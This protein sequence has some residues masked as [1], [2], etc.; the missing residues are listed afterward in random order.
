MKERIA[1]F[2]GVVVVLVLLFGRA[3]F[4]G[5]LPADYT[6]MM[7]TYHLSVICSAYGERLLSGNS[8][9]WME[10]FGA[11]YPIHALW[12]YGSFSTTS[13]FWA[14]L[15]LESAYSWGAIL[16]LAFGAAGIHALMRARG[17]HRAGA[18]TAG[19]VFAVC[20]YTIGKAATG[21]VNQLW[22]LTWAPWVLWA[23]HGAVHDRRHGVSLLALVGALGLLAGHIQIWFFLAPLAVAYALVEVST[24]EARRA[25][26]SRLGLASLLIILITAVQSLPTIEFALIAERPET[27]QSFLEL[28]SAPMYALF[29]K[30]APGMLGFRPGSYLGDEAFDN[31]HSGLGGAAVLLLVL[32]AV[33]RDRRRVLLALAALLG[34]VLAVGVRVPAIGW[35][36]ELPLIGWGR[37]AARS[38]VLTV[39]AG[40]M[41]AGHGVSDLLTARATPW[42]RIA[43]AGG[44]TLAALLTGGIVVKSALSNLVWP[45]AIDGAQMTLTDAFWSVVMPALLLSLLGAV[46]VLAAVLL[47]RRRPMLAPVVAIAALLGVWMAGLPP[48]EPVRTTFFETSWRDRIPVDLADNRVL[49][50]D[51]RVPYVELDGFR[52]FRRPA[53][54]DTRYMGALLEQLG[55]AGAKW[56]DV[57][58][59][60]RRHMHG[61]GPPLGLAQR[62]D[63]FRQGIP[64]IGRGRFFRSA[65]S[66]VPDEEVLQILARGDE[67]LFLATP[68][69]GG[70]ASRGKDVEVRTRG[71]GT[72]LICE[73]EV[74]T[75]G[76]LFV[77]EKW[78]P[79][80][81]CSVNDQPVAISRANVAFRAVPIPVGRSTVKFNYRPRSVLVGALATL[82]GLIL[83][84]VLHYRGRA[85]AVPEAE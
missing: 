11:G 29:S 49:M 4:P 30:V 34:L 56:L 74:P 27:K 71:I 76:W 82:L 20:E 81:N 73:L 18:L 53:H 9:L 70:S 36:H 39:L 61:R 33:T 41:L 15:P 85:P 25:A 1:L 72:E 60:I 8:P 59:E 44:V 55:P 58:T 46:L 65:K 16:H 28:W 43:V 52:G 37:V 10:Q 78:Y 68:E 63:V 48:I 69:V 83:T 3:A 51:L 75:A 35:L 79:G 77:S 14:L 67:A 64:A 57:G 84:G 47:V 13:L 32:I 23:L 26:M 54:V 19:V 6:E 5:H 62:V 45:R 22:A 66:G 7:D 80:W 38:Q 17:V 21:H 50:T 42:K 12:M 40:A 31:E 2:V 24:V